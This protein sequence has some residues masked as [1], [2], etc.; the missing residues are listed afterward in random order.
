MTDV[1]TCYS[2]TFAMTYYDETAILSCYAKTAILSC[3]PMIATL[4]CYAMTG[5]LTCYDNM[6]LCLPLFELAVLLFQGAYVGTHPFQVNRGTHSLIGVPT[7]TI[8]TRP[9]H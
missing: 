3:L 6:S 9:H 4:A 1:L 8:G 7:H 2:Y 5:I